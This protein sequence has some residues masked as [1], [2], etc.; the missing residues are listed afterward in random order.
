MKIAC[1]I[2]FFYPNEVQIQR[3]KEYLEFFEMI[4]IFDNSENEIKYLNDNN[5][6]IYLKNTKNR[7]LSKAFNWMCEEALSKEF[8]YICFL[9]QDSKFEVESL[10]DFKRE[11]LKNDS[12]DTAMFCPNVI[13]N[14]KVKKNQNIE[15][16]E[17]CISSGSF[18][19]VEKFKEFGFDENYFIDG[20]ERDLC[21]QLRKKNQKIKQINNCY[22]I[23]EL[24]YKNKIGVREHNALRN[25]YMF[26][27]RLYFFKKFKRNK[28]ILL[29]KSLKQ[30]FRILILEENKIQKFEYIYKAFFDSL[31]GKYGSYK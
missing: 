11:I 25:Y 22:L 26:R 5:K 15:E 24:G 13:Y 8:D 28:I 6:V 23:Q 14:K 29:L 16:V 7:G 3:I 19:K 31:K 9:D 2:S 17:W 10:C 21:F 27:N 12:Q 30:I 4:F 1:G 18:F 20:I